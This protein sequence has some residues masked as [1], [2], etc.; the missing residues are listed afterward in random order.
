MRKLYISS[1]LDKPETRGLYELCGELDAKVYLSLFRLPFY[2][3]IYVWVVPKYSISAKIDSNYL[4]RVS[5]ATSLTATRAGSG[6]IQNPK[7]PH[8]E[9]H[10]YT[11]HYCLFS[12]FKAQNKKA[13]SKKIIQLI[14]IVNE[15][16]FF[17]AD[18]VN[19]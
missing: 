7:R 15:D 3:K 2:S 12:M 17:S 4:T 6:I 18:N 5:L 19:T 9:L 11:I 1:S 16:G 13:E 10:M 14:M 8:R